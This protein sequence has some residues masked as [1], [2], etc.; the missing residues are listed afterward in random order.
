MAHKK[1]LIGHFVT[2]SNEHIPYMNDITAYDVAFGRDVVEKMQVGDIFESA[3]IEIIPAIFADVGAS[4]VVKRETF[5]Y[6]EAGFLEAVRTHRREIDGI[7]LML[8]GAS[9]VEG[10]GS[11]EH[12]IVAEIRK[13]VGP[14]LPIMVACDPHGNL[15]REYVE[16]CTLIRSYRES[17]HTDEVATWRLVAKRLVEHLQDRQ[18]IHAVYRKLPLI[19][20]GEQS[21]SADE[22]VLSINKRLDE[23][24]ADPRILS[25]S[26]HVGYIRH[27]SPVAGCGVVVVPATG[28]DMEYANRVADELAAYVW[29]RRHEF[30]YTGLT[31]QPDEAL[32]MALREQGGVVVITDSGDNTTSGAAGWNT[33]V[34]RQLLA[35]PHLQKTALVASICDPQTASLL[36]GCATGEHVSI[37]LGVGYDSLSEPVAVDVDVKA[38]GKVLRVATTNM[39]PGVEYPVFGT[40]TLVNITGTSI[41]VIVAASNQ[42]YR[43]S[44]QFQA[45]SVP[46]WR[47]Y[48]I[49]V[50]KQGYV[51]PELKEKAALSVMSL[52]QGATYQDTSSLPLRLIMRPMYPI[53]QI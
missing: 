19:L 14:Y 53:D 44:G 50:V 31:A 42:S 35:V 37:K 18:N 28:E 10:L 5:S 51:F 29:E 46:D 30:H 36:D 15:C 17:P 40:C 23:I 52:T 32:A 2:E 21:V 27:D 13:I 47:A 22:P 20:G 49:V 26:W 41:D 9:E 1:V 4:G 25:A 7:Y 24:E 43:C 38:H 12:H 48:D 34:L 33:F 16:S 3:G 39:E 11:G 45:G 6:I 8:H